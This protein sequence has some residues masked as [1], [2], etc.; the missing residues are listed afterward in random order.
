MAITFGEKEIIR[1]AQV[2]KNDPLTRFETELVIRRKLTDEEWN[3]I[4]KQHKPIE[5]QPKKATKKKSKKPSEEEIKRIK[6]ERAQRRQEPENIY[7]GIQRL[8]Q[9][10]QIVQTGLEHIHKFKTTKSAWKIIGDVDLN[11]LNEAIATLVYTVL[12]GANPNSRVNFQLMVDGEKDQPQ[13]RLM[14]AVDAAELLSEWTAHFMEYQDVDIR[15]ITFKLLQIDMP[16]GG[17]LTHRNEIIKADKSRCIT[18]IV[19][20]DTLCLTRAILV[21]LKSYNQA[22][23]EEIFKDNLM[24]DEINGINYKRQKT[25]YTQ[26]NEGIF[27]AN[28][29]KYFKQPRSTLLTTLANAFH[30]IYEIPIRE[31]GNNLQDAHDIASKIGIQINIYSHDRSLIFSTEPKEI[32]VHLLITAGEKPHFDAITKITAFEPKIPQQACKWC[33]AKTACVKTKIKKCETCFKFFTK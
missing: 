3:S 24:K 1:E 32:K 26:I 21:C 2:F 10:Y 9:P 16:N 17:T 18:Q 20:E 29:L 13:T 19:N 14:D 5:K 8:F 22:K 4:N 28:E 30:R 11:N 7:H 23:L 15:S 31:Y 25:R 33:H 6:E 12:Q 27:S